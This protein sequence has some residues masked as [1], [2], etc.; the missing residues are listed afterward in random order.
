[1]LIHD[2]ELV[3]NFIVFFVFVF[4]TESEKILS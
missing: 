1:M 4:F 2:V 3:L